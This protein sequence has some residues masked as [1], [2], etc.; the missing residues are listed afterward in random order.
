MY[1]VPYPVYVCLFVQQ[2]ETQIHNNYTET[3]P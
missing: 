2:I 3:I 1:T